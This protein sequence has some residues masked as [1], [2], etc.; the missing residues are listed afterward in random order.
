MKHN[1][2]DHHASWAS[3]SWSYSVS[4]RNLTDWTAILLSI[5]LLAI[6]WFLYGKWGAKGARMWDRPPRAELQQQIREEVGQKKIIPPV[7]AEVKLADF[8]E[9]YDAFV[10]SDMEKSLADGKKT[11]VFFHSK[12]CSSCA[13]LHKNIMETDIPQDVQIFKADRDTDNVQ[14]LAK[15]YWVDKYHTVSYPGWGEDGKP[16]NVKGLFDLSSLIGEFEKD[17]VEDSVEPKSDLPDWF[18]Y[19]NTNEYVST[20]VVEEFGS[21][22]IITRATSTPF[23]ARYWFLNNLEV[24]SS[25]EDCNFPDVKVK[26]DQLQKS[27][28]GACWYDLLRW[29]N[30]DFIP[31]RNMSKDELLT[32]L[33]RTKTWFLPE[34]TTPWFKNYFEYAKKN[35]LVDAEASIAE[36]AW[37]VTKKDMG[38]RLYRLSLV[39]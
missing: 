3:K 28:Q 31:D 34:D 2:H 25:P 19:L 37:N 21:D 39:K 9:R 32:V 26:S 38:Q 13:K 30:G 24:K 20:K 18:S 11:A 36:F 5:A 15:E 33:V 27:I 4:S 22:E 6:L 23:L 29:S 17:V 8:K 14:E 16:K 7:P 12:T 10:P 35:G 1:S